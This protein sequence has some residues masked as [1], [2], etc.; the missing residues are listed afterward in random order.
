MVFREKKRWKKKNICLKL[1]YFKFDQVYIKERQHSWYI[2]R[3]YLFMAY[4][5]DVL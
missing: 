4:L 1:N 3:V 5:F 2:Y